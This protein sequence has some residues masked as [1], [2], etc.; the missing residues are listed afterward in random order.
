MRAL[1]AAALAMVTCAAVAAE[2][3]DAHRQAVA[4]RDT[5]WNCLAREYGAGMATKPCRDRISRL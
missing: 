1:L 2:V 3:E 5:Y 4:G